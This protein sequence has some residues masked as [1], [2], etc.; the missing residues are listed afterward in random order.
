[1]L[2]SLRGRFVEIKTIEQ[3]AL[4]SLHRA[5]NLMV[6]QRTQLINALR[7]MLAEFGVYVAKGL[8]RAIGFSQG[9]LAGGKL[10]LPEIAQD[11]VHNCS[12]PDDR[13][14]PRRSA[15]FMARSVLGDIR[16]DVQC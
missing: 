12:I 4:L 10:E 6:R 15:F 5:R 13:I 2:A 7:S 1:M 16:Q 8:A 11:V 14:D 9:V 3:Q